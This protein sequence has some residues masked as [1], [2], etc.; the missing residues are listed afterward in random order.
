MVIKAKNLILGLPTADSTEARPFIDVVR[1]VRQVSTPGK[2]TLLRKEEPVV[3]TSSDN[4]NI[5]VQRKSQFLDDL[6]KE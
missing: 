3:A 4:I 1:E 5:I 6:T 2:P